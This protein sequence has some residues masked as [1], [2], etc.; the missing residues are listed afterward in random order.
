M[1]E[2]PENLIVFVSTLL[3]RLPAMEGRDRANP[4]A[5]RSGRGCAAVTAPAGAGAHSDYV[6]GFCD[7]PEVCSCSCG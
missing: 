5:V 7:T 2:M 3:H 1:G 6:E 4:R